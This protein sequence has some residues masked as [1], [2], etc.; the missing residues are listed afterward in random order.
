[1]HCQARGRDGSGVAWPYRWVARLE[2]GG[3]CVVVLDLCDE[4][5]GVGRRMSVVAGDLDQI[6][7][8]VA[9]IDAGNGPA[10]SGAEHR[11]LLDGNL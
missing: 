6:A 10:S 2:G 5:L 9:D 1:M 8:G 3:G 11:A 4:L 7:I